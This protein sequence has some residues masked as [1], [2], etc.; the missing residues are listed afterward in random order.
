MPVLQGGAPLSGPR[1]ASPA[2][3]VETQKGHLANRPSRGVA[4]RAD[5]VVVGA[6]AIGASTA[7]FLAETGFSNV[8]LL[9]RGTLAGGS[10]SKA[11]GVVSRQLW[12]DLDV[13]LVQR[14]MEAMDRLPLGDGATGLRR[15]GLL[16]LVGEDGV[17]LANRRV[18]MWRDLDVEVEV[19]P[20]DGIADRWP[21]LV[22]GEAA[23]G[24]WTPHDGFADPYEI[25]SAIAGGARE[26]GVELRQG[27]EVTALVLRG[28]SIHG[29]Q[30]T[31]GEVRTENVVVAAGPWSAK[32]AGLAGV[33]LPLKPYRAQL[34]ASRP[35]EVG[36]IPIVHDLSSKVYFFQEV[37]GSILAG[38]GTEE[39]ESDPDA[40]D[41]Q[42]DFAF[43]EDTARKMSRLWPA[44][45]D[46]EFLRG[47]AGLCA[48]TPD[49]RLLIGPHPEVE[50]LVFAT[51]D[52]GFG[53]MRSVAIGECTAAI[54]AGERPPLDVAR[55]RLDRFDDLARDW[56]IREGFTL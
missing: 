47:W 30:T 38:D 39:R 33:D 2:A 45:S 9:D 22:A 18:A 3:L 16:R 29:V 40:F 34:M 52:N 11:A 17:A 54:V 42:P 24:L 48:A 20:V 10:T 23:V 21:D 37:G 44:A 28:G 53:F 6:G 41:A 46:A 12:D 14:S 13:R 7:F 8:V 25:A 5:V 15:V 27:T 43:I 56:P 55:C 19:I 49:R 50:G 31:R 51:G 1:Q 4:G 26:R 36:P 35:R 32:V